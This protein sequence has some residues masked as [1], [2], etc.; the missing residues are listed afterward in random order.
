[1]LVYGFM[2]LLQ[3]GCLWDDE[4]YGMNYSLDDDIQYLKHVG[5]ARADDFARLG[6]K[7]V[8][9]LVFTFPRDMSDRSQYY[10]VH[11]FPDDRPGS[12][13]ATAIGVDERQVRRNRYARGGQGGRNGLTITT[14]EMTVDGGGI[15]EA[16]WF[17]QP[18]LKDKL[19]QQRVVVH[20]KGKRDRDRLR[21]EHPQ[22]EIIP[23][24]AT[25]DSLNFG[26]IVP[27]YPCTG[28]LNQTVWRRVMAHALETRLD[29][30]EETL[31]P[32]FLA[33][34]GFP[35]LR[36]AVK[37]MHFPEDAEKWRLAR[38]R[39]VWEECFF[40]QLTLLAA[41]RHALHDFPGRCFQVG[42][43]LDSRIRRLFPFH[44]TAAQNRAIRE[45]VGDMESPLPMQRLLQGDVGSGKTA[46][47]AYA[48]LAAVANKAQVCI[49]APT[50]ILARQHHETFARF[51][52]NSRNAR[53]RM[54]VL[55][56]GMTQAERSVVL[57]RLANGT[58]DIVAATH[59]AISESVAFH[60]LGLVVID[61]QHKF[62]VRQRDGLVRK[63]VR[64]DLLVMTATPI[65]RS[66]A[67]SVYGDLDV[68]VID[69]M[70]PGR[71][72]VATELLPL[73]G[74]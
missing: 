31:A 36:Q 6:V 19:L 5:P 58:L 14:F 43:E 29:L 10:T 38:R 71:K 16:V 13:I 8:R 69:E 72:P 66:L 33:G 12:V 44:P 62:G 4:T 21:M 28:D 55:V 23:G 7:T 15:L 27:I 9:D 3:Y 48:M 39:L 70:P 49:M 50:G 53:V 51:L 64:P 24:D 42:P 26:R 32:G 63:G 45:I 47:A 54:G 46:V 68:S 41:R 25:L 1:M 60:D 22:F 11:D 67:L 18:W 59:S 40:L 34:L 61:E 20:G 30:L 17:N 37:A 57:D 56:G 2:M 65:P 74:Q 35:D 52:A 73:S